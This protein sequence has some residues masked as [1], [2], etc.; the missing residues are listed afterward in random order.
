MDLTI[1]QALS[2]CCLVGEQ[3]NA[4]QI[5][6]PGDPRLEEGHTGQPL[7]LQSSGP[8]TLGK[9]SPGGVSNLGTLSNLEPPRTLLEPQPQGITAGLI[10]NSSRSLGSAPSSARGSLS[11]EE[12]QKEK[13]RLQD[14]VKEFAKSVVQGLQCQH[15]PNGTGAP[16][17]ASYSFFE[18]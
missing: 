6:Y 15:L 12:R 5:S 1:R 16:R 10:P 2:C 11:P 13:E 4:H 8:G 14:M 7:L 18:L 17:C 3:T 9:M